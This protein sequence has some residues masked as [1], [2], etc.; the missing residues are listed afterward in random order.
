[1]AWRNAARMKECGWIRHWGEWVTR[2]PHGW[3]YSAERHEPDGGQ[4]SKSSGYF[5]TAY[6]AAMGAKAFRRGVDGRWR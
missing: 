5:D 4:V 1:M 3:I 2:L 6:G